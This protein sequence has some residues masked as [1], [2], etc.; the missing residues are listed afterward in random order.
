MV[1]F[2]LRN[3]I[4]VAKEAFEPILKYLCHH[5]EK[6]V[7]QAVEI[8]GFTPISR[9]ELDSIIYTEILKFLLKLLRK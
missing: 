3:V 6:S 7:A 2:L 1:L 8:L 5:P 9:K 4:M